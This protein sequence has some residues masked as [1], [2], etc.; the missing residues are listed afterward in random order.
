MS[1]L[2]ILF[3]ILIKPLELVFEGI[4]AVSH[5]IVP[6]PAVNLVIMSLAINF[7]V[8]PLYQQ[9]VKCASEGHSGHLSYRIKMEN[10]TTNI[11]FQHYISIF[12][13]SILWALF[14]QDKRIGGAA[15]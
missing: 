10:L 1:F 6:N 14:C 3:T 15:F 8:L 5:D 12:Y 11:T 4:F 2:D 13:Y 7:L 9:F